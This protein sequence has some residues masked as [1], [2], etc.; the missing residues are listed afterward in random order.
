MMAIVHPSTRENKI[1]MTFYV[2][3]DTPSEVK[4]MAR[5]LVMQ[6]LWIL[7]ENSMFLSK[8]QRTLLGELIKE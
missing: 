8:D 6:A 1:S 4:Q 2:H 7:H 5:D 3:V